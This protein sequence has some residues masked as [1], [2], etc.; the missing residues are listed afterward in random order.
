MQKKRVFPEDIF[1]NDFF[2]NA[3]PVRLVTLNIN[4][5][6]L[7]VIFFCFYSDKSC[8]LFGRKK[9]FVPVLLFILRQTIEL[10][11]T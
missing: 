8:S 10:D 1:K 5:C 3:E 2:K 7:H 4:L 11:M 6:N 9:P